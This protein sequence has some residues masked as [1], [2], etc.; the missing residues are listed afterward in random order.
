MYQYIFILGS[1]P[2]L[3]NAE[4]DSFF[5]QP[6]ITSLTP[7]IILLKFSQ[8]LIEPQKILDRLGGTIKIIEH[9]STSHDDYQT[10]IQDFLIQYPNLPRDI[11]VSYY[12]FN[13]NFFTKLI[14]LKKD[15]R[16]QQLSIRLITNQ[17]GSPLNAATLTKNQ[18]TTKGLEVVSVKT[19]DTIYTGTTLAYQNIDWYTQRDYGKP[20]PDPVSGMLPPKLAQIMLNLAH[21]KPQE[22]IYDPFCG[23]GVILQ[24]ALL[25]NFHIIGSD[26]SPIAINNTIANLKWLISSF[27]LSRPN[28]RQ[29]LPKSIFLA[30]ATTNQLSQP[31]DAIVTEP[32]LGPP[33]KNT[34]D[35]SLAQ[36][37][38]KQLFPL[39]SR[40]LHNV[41]HN[42][43]SQG[44]LV[45]VLPVFQTST[46]PIIFPLSSL[47]DQK[48]QKNYTIIRSNLIYRQP[49][50][51]IHRQILVLQKI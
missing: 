9:K 16:K 12:H 20:K 3:S 10:T 47:L 18:L 33:L 41:H 39:Y 24:E 14:N 42:L 2:D 50:Q 11:G 38:I 21:L 30:D 44:Y 6:S 7:N 4:I 1:N 19:A 31:A 13:T 15:L 45:L 27:S 51:H 17:D 49:K 46:S 29:T 48:L 22:T 35:Q 5:D 32:F 34:I 23:S 40:F 28:Y 36:E 26:I 25:Q 8:P 43:K 37:R